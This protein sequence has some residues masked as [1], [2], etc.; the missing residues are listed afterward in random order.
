MSLNSIVLKSLFI[1]KQAESY[2]PRPRLGVR[3]NKATGSLLT[4]VTPSPRNVRHWTPALR[5][6]I[7]NAIHQQIKRQS[8]N[9]T[10][11]WAPREHI[12]LF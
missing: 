10:Q 12:I 8:K 7:P 1:K 3:C 11:C 6:A 2:V 9:D 4:S 5:A